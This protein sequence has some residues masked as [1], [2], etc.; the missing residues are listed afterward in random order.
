M[1]KAHPTHVTRDSHS[2]GFNLKKSSFCVAQACPKLT[3]LLSLSFKYLNYRHA[4]PC[5]IYYLFFQIIV[6]TMTKICCYSLL[7]F[8]KM[9]FTYNTIDVVNKIC[10]SQEYF[11]DDFIFIR[12]FRIEC[13][14]TIHTTKKTYYWEIN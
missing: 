6:L 2:S 13:L 14:C 3:P 7:D 10:N 1:S 12:W 11:E 5:P 4:L 9:H 8:Y